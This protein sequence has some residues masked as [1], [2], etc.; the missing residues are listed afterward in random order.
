M[1][2]E[3]LS[4]SEF[5]A[6]VERS[7]VYLEEL[8]CQWDA[9]ELLRDPGPRI[10]IAEHCQPICTVLQ[11]ALVD[12]LRS[13]GIRPAATVGCVFSP[14]SSPPEGRFELTLSSSTGTQ[15]VK[16]APPMQQVVSRIETPSKSLI[17]VATTAA[18]SKSGSKTGKALCWL[19]GSLPPRP[20]HTSTK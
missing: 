15:V 17:S 14:P 18:R 5:K 1:G 3:L 9:A 6:S 19:Q 11:V 8:G 16:S 20:R 12:M 4:D 13:W 2:R 7:Q 10:N